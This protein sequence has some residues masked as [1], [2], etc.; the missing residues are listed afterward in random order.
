MP[1][2]LTE[3]RGVPGCRP[4]TPIRSATYPRNT[5]NSPQSVPSYS[6]PFLA[7]TDRPL[8]DTPNPALSTPTLLAPSRL[9][10]PQQHRPPWPCLSRSRQINPDQLVRFN[11]LHFHPTP[12]PLANSFLPSARQRRPASSYQ[13]SSSLAT[14]DFPFLCRSCLSCPYLHR[15]TMPCCAEPTPTPPSAPPLASSRHPNTDSPELSC[16]GLVTPAQHRH[17]ASAPPESH[18]LRRVNKINADAH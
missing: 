12:T 9:L 5:D 17:I 10:I 6:N 7:N 14:T 16:T 1:P 3:P 18:Q 15:H 8:L 2:L 4:D 13:I 11:P